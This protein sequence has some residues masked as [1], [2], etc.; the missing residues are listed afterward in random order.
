MKKNK[1]K[2]EPRLIP[3]MFRRSHFG[4]SKKF[5]LNSRLLKIIYFF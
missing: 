4:V 5:A 3:V 1:K 2:L